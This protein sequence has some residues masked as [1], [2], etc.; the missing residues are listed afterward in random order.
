MLNPKLDTFLKVANEGSF[1]K[2]AEELFL[3]PPAV[4]KQINALEL[5]LGFELFER[6]KRGLRL[7]EAGESFYK[8]AKYLVQYYNGSVERA[9]MASQTDRDFLRIGVSI[10]TPGQFIV[11][12]WEKVYG[13]LPG[14]K[15][16]FVP[17]QNTPEVAKEGERNFG[18][19]VDLVIGT[20]DEHFLQER[21]CDA[22]WLSDEPLRV[23]VPFHHPLH[24]KDNLSVQDLYGHTLHIIQREWNEGMDALRDDLAQNH[25]QIGIVTFAFYQ[26]EAFNQCE[27][28]EHLMVTID[29]WKDVHPLMKV[30]PVDWCH[31]IHFGLL[32][33]PVPSRTVRRFLDAVRRVAGKKDL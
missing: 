10:M 20:F 1:N 26:V 22:T 6:T 27:R 8:D 7:T 2:A 25:P 15:F 23:G 11:E 9:R 13:D 5:E 19:D 18:R 32:H 29:P 4:I 28:E 24:T 12:L 30:L 21:G 17:F 33:S 14:L 16:Q 3:S 31:K